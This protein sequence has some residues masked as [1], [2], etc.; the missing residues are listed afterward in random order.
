MSP[1]VALL[2]IVLGQQDTSSQLPDTV[3][4][5]RLDEFITAFNT[6]DKRLVQDMVGRSFAKS[7]L[8]TTAK[9]EWATKIASAFEVAPISVD[10]VLKSAENLIIVRIKSRSIQPKAIRLDLETEVP[11]GI[12]A[13]SM[14]SPSDLTNSGPPRKYTKWAKLSELAV[15]LR[16]DYKLPGLEIGTKALGKKSEIS[17]IGLRSTDGTDVF[18]NADRIWIGGAGKALTATLVAKL[19]EEKKLSW[20]TP[21]SAALPGIPM[22]DDYKAITIEQLLH[23]QANLPQHP[24]IT[25]TK[26]EAALSNAET[27]MQARKVLVTVILNTVP[28]KQSNT[29]FSDGDMDYVVA[30]HVLERL[31]GREYEWLLNSHLLIPMKLRTVL[32]QPLCTDGQVG[33]A[34]SVY[35]H[36]RGD[37][38]GYAPYLLPGSKLELAMAPA[39]SCITCSMD[40]LLRFAEFHLKGLQGNAEVLSAES[41]QKL[42]SDLDGKGVPCGW[43][44]NPTF[45]DETCQAIST[46]NGIFTTD[47]T[48]WPDAGIVV[49]ASTNCAP[50]KRPSPTIQAIIAAKDRIEKKN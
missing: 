29:Q 34:G 1:L 46:S 18:D 12:V 14:G 19:I 49:A 16:E 48:I 39:G 17:A 28:D 33:S 2:A 47:L 36:M 50:A 31:I 45:A 8:K 30:A 9:E 23:H 4:G 3:A 43:T 38:G 40:D 10:K 32:V 25:G 21:L 6:K 44:T 22:L 42:H 15:M 5:R 11:F 41:Y 13:A 20:N 35:G 26:A 37:I 7:A 27:G 24:L